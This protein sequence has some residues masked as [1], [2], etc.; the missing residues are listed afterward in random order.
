LVKKQGLLK[1]NPNIRGRVVGNDNFFAPIF[2]LSSD[3]GPDAPE[4]LSRLIGGDERFFFASPSEAERNYNYNDNTVL[5]SAIKAGYRG[6]FWDIL[7][8]IGK[9]V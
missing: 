2:Y 7:R 3:L 4:Y 1:G 5:V 6:A 9:N 8:R